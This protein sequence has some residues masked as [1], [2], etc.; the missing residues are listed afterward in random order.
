MRCSVSTRGFDNTL[1]T[2]TCQ[3]FR[4]NQNLGP[5]QLA[6]KWHSYEDLYL[7]DE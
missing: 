5:G 2:A 7:C 3:N 6:V 1:I 4:Y